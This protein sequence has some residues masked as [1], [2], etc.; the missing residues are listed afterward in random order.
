M[1]MMWTEGEIGGKYFINEHDLIAVAVYDHPRY[2][3]PAFSGSWILVGFKNVEKFGRL[4]RKTYSVEELSKMN[5][6]QMFFKNGRPRFVMVDN[7]HG[8]MRFWSK[9]V[10]SVML[11]A[12]DT[13][14]YEDMEVSV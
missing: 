11:L 12:P 4:S 1:Y 9:R 6:D 10:L 3:K 13:L 2:R 5:K 14:E 7:D 8:T